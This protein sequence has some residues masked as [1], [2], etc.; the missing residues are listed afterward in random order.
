MQVEIE[1][2]NL[3]KAKTMLQNLQYK[4][5]FFFDGRIHEIGQFDP[6]IHQNPAHAWQPGESKGFDKDL[7]V[8]NFFFVPN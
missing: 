8:V 2:K 3:T 6:T 1:L 4:G 7:F 5:L